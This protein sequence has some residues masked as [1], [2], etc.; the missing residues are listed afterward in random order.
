[1]LQSF[2]AVFGVINTQV[3]FSS[4]LLFF[5]GYVIAPTAYYKEI[6]WLTAYPF[7][8]I[9]LMD[10][11]F[12]KKHH[13]LKI[14][15]ILISLNTISLFVNLLSAWGVILPFFF[16]IYMGINIGIVMYHSLEGR[17]Y[18][19]G[20]LNPVAILELPAAWL[21]IAMAIQ[22]SLTH[23]FELNELAIV[24]FNQYLHYF[25]MTILPI[26]LIAAVIETILI[27]KAEKINK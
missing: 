3:F 23:Y 2:L 7:F 27:A 12:K 20:L 16:I 1:M 11:F 24:S 21:S 8:I 26:L 14:F 22:F 4:V 17:F 13:P 19:L 5:V 15:L 6:K 18:Y 9:K 10:Q 25:V